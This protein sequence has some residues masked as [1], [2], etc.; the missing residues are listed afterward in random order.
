MHLLPEAIK[1]NKKPN[2]K[3]LAFLK[4]ENI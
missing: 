2:N 4:K 1:H 3:G